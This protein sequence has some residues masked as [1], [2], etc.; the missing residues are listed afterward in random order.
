MPTLDEQTILALSRG[1]HGDPFAVLGPHVVRRGRQTT[2]TVR[3]VLPRMAQVTLL[4]SNGTRT[5][6]QVM[7]RIHPEGVFEAVFPRRRTPFPYRLQLTDHDDRTTVIEDPYR[8]PTVWGETDLHLFGE[9][10]HYRAYDK[11][12]AHLVR[13]NGIPG[14]VF[15]V[16]APNAHRVSVVGDFNQWDGRV[17]PMRRH[18]STGLWELFIP[19]V[20]AGARYKYELL[21]RTG[22]PLALKVDP[23]A[24][25][26][27][28]DTPRTAAVVTDLR[29]QWGDAEWMARRGEKNALDAPISIYELHLGSWQRLPEAHNRRL[30]YREVA[31]ALAP[32][33]AALRYTHVELLPVTEH[34]FY[35]SWGYQPLGYFAPTRRY[36]TP[37]DFMYF[38]DYLHQFG[39][40]VIIDW[41]PAHFPRDPHGLGYFDGTHLYEHADP[42]QR[43]HQD[44]GTLVFNYGRTEVANFLLNSALFWLDRYHLDGLRVD[45][46]ASMLYLDYSRQ[47]GEWIPNI[48]G[49][50]ENLEAI[51]FLKRLN[52]VVYHYHPDV[53]TIAEESTAWPLVSRPPDTGGL[54]FKFKW[55]LGWMHDVLDYMGKEPVHRKHHHRN[56]TFGLLY[57]W[58]ENFILPLSHDEVVH[59]KGSMRG[60]MPGDDWQGFANLR[61][62]YGFMYGYPGK[63]LLFM[64]GE[65]GQSAEWN[66]D[67]SLDWDLLGKGRYHAG[68]LRLV[69]HLNHLYRSQ[70][71]LHE[72]DCEPMGFRWISCDDAEQS[73]VAFLRRAHDPDNYVLVVCNFTPVPRHDYRL[74]VPRGGYWQELLNTDAAAYGG[75]NVGNGGGVWAEDVP[76]HEQPSSVVL[77]LP[78]LAALFLQPR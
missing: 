51:A 8:F 65:F 44:W 18:P 50:N 38:V 47:P 4:P 77:T 61:L 9:G 17:H 2:V 36:G 27:E 20:T 59:G 45:A 69:Q 13:L 57:A 55:N 10:T 12:G 22:E 35:G 15:S 3:A 60:K 33:L 14:V 53:M 16:W 1:E 66:H 52:E 28:P 40:G 62:L 23:Y 6:P 7:D 67:Q 39:I 29:Y 42:R 46:V 5:P 41:V 26:F 48:Y 43:E 74:G 64:G 71:A 25:A 54:G 70:A 49:G 56:L 31:R 76:E 68:M 30:T 78:P 24:F 32:Y 19:G 34:P 58:Q 21:S 37:Q 72:V 75:S 11:L 73:V 63:K